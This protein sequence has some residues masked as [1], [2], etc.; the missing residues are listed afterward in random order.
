MIH[1][2]VALDLVELDLIEANKSEKLISESQH[3]GQINA[4]IMVGHGQ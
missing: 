4:N 1:P 2:G 3:P